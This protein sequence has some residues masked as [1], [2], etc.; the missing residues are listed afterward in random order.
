MKRYIK[1]VLII[2]LVTSFVSCD[3]YLATESGST[4]TEGTVFSSLDFA[5]KAVSG[6]YERLTN[7]YLY[8]YFLPSYKFD[9]DIGVSLRTLNGGQV[10]I[11][12]YAATEG[13]NYIKQVWDILYETIERANICIDN[14]PVSP[15]WNG[16]NADDARYLYGQ[17]VT[18]RAYLYSELISQW[19]D[20]PF[21]I[22]SSQNGDE[23]N[24]P[25]TDRDEIYEY[26]VQDLKDVED[27]VPWMSTTTEKITKGFVKGLRARIALAY[28]GYSLRN[29]TL[30]TRRGRKWEEYYKIANQECKE[31][32]ESG[33]HSLNPDFK[34][35]FTT[36]HAYKMDLSYKEVLFEVASGR[37]YSGQLGWVIGMTCAA[38]SMYGAGNNP[39]FLVPPSYFYSFDTKDTRR[40]VS[41][42]LYDYR[43]T[44]ANLNKQ[45][46][47]GALPQ[48]FRHCKWR[49]PWLVPLL[50]GSG[51]YTG[52]NFPMMRYSDILLMYA[53]TENQ[54]NGPT[55]S[56]KEA[57]SL[58]RQRAFAKELWTEKVTNYVNSV[59]ASKE[60][61]FNAIVDERAWEFGGE[62]VRKADLVRWNLLGE[63]LNQMKADVQDLKNRQGKF[64]FVPK[65]V[66]YKYEADG[67]TLNFL[68]PDYQISDAAVSGYTKVAWLASTAAGWTS[69]E[70]ILKLIAFDPSKNNHLQ[71]ISIQTITESNGVLSNDQIP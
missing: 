66:F 20:V 68:N 46:D 10:N 22:K 12:H 23:F 31:I 29:K 27:Y 1:I 42:E 14:L 69:L 63:K 38:T 57:L 8:Q 2:T 65:Y 5:Q 52:V 58:V 9:H 54:M 56:A 3:D 4:F 33:K 32:I 35:I 43:S 15:L 36:L 34:N 49:R 45:M 7:N 59:S 51:S 17:A 26:L 11:S 67:L 16:E 40:N 6:I 53:E 48:Y 18:L 19:G 55:S 50:P 60:S 41:V 21:K 71:P 30:E 64:A 61:F 47:I 62:M 37:S 44:G 25:K 24:Q 70:N 39:Q 28:A 13:G